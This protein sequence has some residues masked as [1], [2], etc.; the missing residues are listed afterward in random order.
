MQILPVK[1][2]SVG[3]YYFDDVIRGYEEASEF[4]GRK[5]EESYPDLKKYFNKKAEHLNLKKSVLIE[6]RKDEI[7]NASEHYENGIL[8]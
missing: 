7:Y 8:C 3:S 1:K 2:S 6:K 4:H 5:L